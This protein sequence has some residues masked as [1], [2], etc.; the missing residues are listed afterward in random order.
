MCYRISI[1]RIYD[2]VLT[3]CVRIFFYQLIKRIICIS[4]ARIPVIRQRFANND[5]DHIP[6]TAGSGR[7]TNHCVP[8]PRIVPVLLKI[9][10]HGPLVD[11]LPDL[12]MQL[13]YPLKRLSVDALPELRGVL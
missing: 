11:D 1:F 2:A 6:P 7:R 3:D 12:G 8:F 4:S 13:L 10:L 9:R 5:P